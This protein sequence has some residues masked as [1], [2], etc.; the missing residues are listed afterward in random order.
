MNTDT[1]AFAAL[2]R[3]V[4]V[5]GLSFALIALLWAVAGAVVAGEVVQ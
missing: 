1:S 3:F 4:A 5:L 2:L